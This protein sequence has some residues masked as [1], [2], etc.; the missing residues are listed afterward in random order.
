MRK[1]KKSDKNLYYTLVET[2]EQL[3]RFYAG[4]KGIQWMAF[5]TEFIPEKYFRSKLCVISVATPNGNYVLDVVKLDKMDGFLRLVGDPGIL[6]I[7]HAGENDYRILVTDYNAKPKNIF[8][9]QLSYGFLNRD[10]PLGLQYLVEKELKIWMNKGEL[11]SDWEQRPLTPEQMKYAVGDVINL[12][13]LMKVL[14]RKLKK[15]GKLEWSNEENSQWEQ[16]GYFSAESVEFVNFFTGISTRGLSRQQK[17]LL[18]RLHLWRYEEAAKRNCPLN[19]VLKTWLLNSI[20]R[21]IKGGK[22]ALLKD[23]TIP[24]GIVNHYW[25]MFERFY[26][27]KATGKERELLALIPGEG[28]G[29]P[30]RTVVIEMLYP[31]I[32]LKALDQGISPNLVISKKEMNK[33]KANRYY[34]P[35]YLEGG[36]RRKLLGPDILHWLRKRYPMDITVKNN[37]CI[38]T[39]RNQGGFSSVFISP[40]KKFTAGGSLIKRFQGWFFKIIKRS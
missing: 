13:P 12:Y 29:D 18:V 28:N 26:H 35:S 38:L 2:G 22:H 17:V 5:D 25:P 6:K 23:R 37:S 15:R 1:K 10:Y 16:P 31:I 39:M 36:W 33:M 34:Y 11:R 8:D 30:R 32:K 40:G 3:D 27:K 20:V 14:K 7:T 9:T 4:N 21:N 24:D 19:Q